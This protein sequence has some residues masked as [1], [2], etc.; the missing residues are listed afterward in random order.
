MR[1]WVWV[2]IFFTDKMRS[3]WGGG[4]FDKNN[5]LIHMAFRSGL[6]IRGGSGTR[7]P[8]SLRWRWGRR[9]V[10]LP[11][12]GRGRTEGPPVA[13]VG[14]RPSMP[15]WATWSPWERAAG[16][17]EPAEHVGQPALWTY[18]ERRPWM[19]FYNGELT[20]HEYQRTKSVYHSKRMDGP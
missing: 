9:T 10:R 15:A 20:D 12:R 11:A 7:R 3:R 17:H 5:E 16:H 19:G 8:W 13:K 18:W 14:G 1:F 2:R 4:G 6:G